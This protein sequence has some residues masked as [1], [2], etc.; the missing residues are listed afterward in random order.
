MHIMK[1]KREISHY[2]TDLH[3][4]LKGKLLNNVTYKTEGKLFLR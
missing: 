3:A 2:Y 1:W 4:Q